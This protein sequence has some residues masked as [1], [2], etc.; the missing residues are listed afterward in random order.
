ME[1]ESLLP[2]FR[3]PQRAGRGFPWTQAVSYAIGPV[4]LMNA[5]R[6]FRFSRKPKPKP[7]G[8]FVGRLVQGVL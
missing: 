3:V 6:S 8:D 2:K 5:S 7:R 4:W 1:L